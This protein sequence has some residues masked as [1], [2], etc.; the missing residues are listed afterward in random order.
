MFVVGVDF[1]L[2]A[3]AGGRDL[4]SFIWVGRCP[5]VLR[6]GAHAR[7]G[8]VHVNFPC[9]WRCLLLTDESRRGAGG[10]MGRVLRLLPED[11][12]LATFETVA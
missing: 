9:F 3:V 8:A 6:A 12:P 7:S 4:W 2:K 11:G 1:S 5:G 10:E